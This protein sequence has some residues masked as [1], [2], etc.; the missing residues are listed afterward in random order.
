[1]P[2]LEGIAE[3][4]WAG[5]NVSMSRWRGDDP[6][7]RTDP[8]NDVVGFDGMNMAHFGH[9]PRGTRS[10]W[11]RGTVRP[12]DFAEVNLGLTPMEALEEARRCFN[13]AVCNECELC[14]IFCPDVAITR[15]PEGHGFDIDLN[16]CK[17]CGVCA[18][19]CPRGAI[20]MTREG[21]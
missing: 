4:R 17:G 13:C 12:L 5:G 9:V 1:V 11:W 6:V 18:M 2:P 20:V 16:Y 15:Q 14:L 7:E 3:L 8:R 10:T 21:L 19:E